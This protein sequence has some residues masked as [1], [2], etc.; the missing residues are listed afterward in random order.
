MKKVIVLFALIAAFAATSFA[1]TDNQAAPTATQETM[2]H[3]GG[4]KGGKH[5]GAGMDMKKQLNL[6][7]EQESKMKTIGGTYRGKMKALKSDNSLSKDQKKAQFAE[8]QKA[9][10]AEIKGTLNGDQYAKFTELK[11]QRR[12][13]MKAHKGGKGGKVRRGQQGQN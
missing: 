12:D 13:T 6:T 11:K 9:H 2:K 10:D 1:Q 3:K 7:A 5:A 4:R 8:L